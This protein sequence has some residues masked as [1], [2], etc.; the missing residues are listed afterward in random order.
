MWAALCRACYMLDGTNMADQSE[1]GT[2]LLQS[3][4]AATKARPVIVFAAG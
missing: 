1:V 2:M 4:S 3:R